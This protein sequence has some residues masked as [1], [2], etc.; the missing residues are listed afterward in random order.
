MPESVLIVTLPSTA[1]P[2]AVKKAVS[3]VS[4]VT[5]VDLYV[6]SQK[7]AV[8]Y[9]RDAEGGSQTL[10]EIKRVIAPFLA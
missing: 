4:G 10:T 5:S 3:K 2:Y 1:E 9:V 8:R 7:L 6:F